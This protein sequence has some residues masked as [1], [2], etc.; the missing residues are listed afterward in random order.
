MAR[1]VVRDPSTQLRPLKRRYQYFS[2]FFPQFGLA[3]KQPQTPCQTCLFGWA[4]S[5]WSGASLGSVQMTPLTRTKLTKV[6][7]SFVKSGVK[8]ISYL[9]PISHLPWLIIIL[10][11]FLTSAILTVCQ[12]C[13]IFCQFRGI[14]VRPSSIFSMAERL[15]LELPDKVLKFIILDVDYKAKKINVPS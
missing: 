2:P 14:L 6:Q 10:L 1:G 8:N 9:S 5:K 4:S 7:S 13:R 3:L 15:E 11:F 12:N